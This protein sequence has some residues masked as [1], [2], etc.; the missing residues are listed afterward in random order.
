MCGRNEAKLPLAT[1]RFYAGRLGSSAV[2]SRP[3]HLALMSTCL[4]SEFIGSIKNEKWKFSIQSLFGDIG[5]FR[6]Q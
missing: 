3:N 5:D 4:P 2:H 1:N 6:E